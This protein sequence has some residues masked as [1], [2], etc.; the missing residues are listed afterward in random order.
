MG[1]VEV[2]NNVQNRNSK[3]LLKIFKYGEAES[4]FP[5]YLLNDIEEDFEDDY[6]E[7]IIMLVT[8]TEDSQEADRFRKFTEGG[9][10][11]VTV[12]DGVVYINCD[13][14][15]DGSYL[16]PDLFTM[17]FE[18]D[19]TEKHFKEELDICLKELG[20]KNTA[21]MMQ[22]ENR[23]SKVNIPLNEGEFVAWMVD[24]D[25][26]MTPFR[27]KKECLE[28]RNSAWAGQYKSVAEMDRLIPAV[29]YVFAGK[30]GMEENVPVC[31]V[32]ERISTKTEIE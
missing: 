14:N 9:N 3:E 29:R 31:S 12:L 15:E 24:G 10:I 26:D 11:F 2:K 17:N 13:G 6:A 18:W 20:Y 32:K 4:F 30:S 7:V 22:T 19:G 27:T 25:P 5:G 21:E 16:E 1:T 28:F 23:N 8:S